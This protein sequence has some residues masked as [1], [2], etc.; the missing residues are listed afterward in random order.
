ME[1]K[2]NLI[3]LM[4]QAISRR[5]SLHV[6]VRDYE[7]AACDFRSLISVLETQSNEKAKQSNSPSGSNGGKE[8]RQA[9]QRLLSVEEQAKKGTALDFYLIL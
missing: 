8:S 1:A 7:Q 4:L 3:A 2:G 6:M 5:A 9:H